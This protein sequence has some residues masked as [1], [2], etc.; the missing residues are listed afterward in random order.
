MAIETYELPLKEI[1]PITEGGTGANTA[2][3]AREALGLGNVAVED[4]LPINKGGTGGNTFVESASIS[5]KVI[6]L[7]MSDGSNKTLTTQD[8]IMEFPAPNYSKGYITVSQGVDN[9][10]TKN[11]FIYVRHNHPSTDSTYAKVFINGKEFPSVI[12]NNYS[13]DSILYPVVKGDVVKVESSD[14]TTNKTKV[15][16]MQARW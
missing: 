7:N 8:T 12:A 13:S 3:G 11:G 5:D 2:A 14:G 9:T 4:I 10:M 6:T 15:Y 16:F 1:I